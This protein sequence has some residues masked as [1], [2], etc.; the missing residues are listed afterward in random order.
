ML[1]H[2]L[3]KIDDVQM[4]GAHALALAALH[5]VAGFAVPG[6][7]VLVVGE[8]DGPALFR[9]ILPHVLVVDGEVLGDADVLGTAL[10]A[11]MAGGA[12]D[13]DLAVDDLRRPEAEPRLLRV[14]GSK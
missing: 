7:E 9:Q 14:S 5:A 10:G 6:G 8:V 1:C 13:G 11:V 12:G 2:V 4:L 3:E